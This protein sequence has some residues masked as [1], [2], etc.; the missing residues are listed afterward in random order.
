MPFDASGNF[1][2]NYNFV[3]DATNGIKILAARVDGEF[4]NFATGMN[5]VF[6]RDG[7]VPM[8]ADLRMNINGI[9]GLK[10]GALGSPAIKFNTDPN[11]G[12]YLPGLN[13]YGIQVNSIQRGVFTTAGFDVTGNFTA[14]GTISEGGTLLSAKYATLAS[15]TFTGAPLA[16]TATGGTNTTQLATTAFVQGAIAPLAPQAAPT[17][18]NPVTINGASGS[19]RQLV[20]ATAGT[21]VAEIAL[22]TDNVTLRRNAPTA[23]RFDIAGATVMTANATSLALAVPVNA[24]GFDATYGVAFKQS[25][26]GQV[27]YH[28]YNGGAN[29][30]WLT[31]QPAHASGDEYRIATYVGGAT[32]DR[33]TISPSGVATFPT[34]SLNVA[35]AI[36]ATGASASVTSNNQAGAGYWSAYNFNNVFNLY[37]SSTNAVK[38]SVTDTGAITTSG[39]LNCDDITTKRASSPTTGAI[40]FGNSGS[41]YLYWDG[42]GFTL[43]GS[44]AVGGNITSSSDARLKTNVRDLENPL[45]LVKAFRPVR[46][47]MYGKADIGFVAQEM[48]QVLPEVVVRDAKGFMSIDYGRLTAVLAGAVQNL[49]ARLNRIEAA[50][51]L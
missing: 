2:R 48:Q 37:F 27:G 29:C 45:A 4:D 30:E 51:G 3:Q 9:T 32:T 1:T 44:L 41:R 43:Q 35:G 7:R 11:T 38:F 36:N 25:R 12:P 21:N 50:L 17:F 47:D 42:A 33:L 40:F 20:Y 28:M 19:S 23:H 49:D 6:F 8:Q 26:T 24:S 22:L 39:A 15:P 14:S 34:G 18:T 5:A 31:Y 10:D 13:Q 46:F 16:P